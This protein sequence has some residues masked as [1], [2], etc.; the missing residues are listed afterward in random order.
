MRILVVEDEKKIAG[1]IRRGLKEENYS[2]DIAYDG[3]EGHFLAKTNEYDLI[4]LD[5]MLPKL[6]GLT[7]C[8]KLRN[9]IM[10][11]FQE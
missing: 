9:R 7:L 8:R 5:L 1:F 6:D 3:E 10:Y 4:I 11:I 2:V